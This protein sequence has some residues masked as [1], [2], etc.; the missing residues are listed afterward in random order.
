VTSTAVLSFWNW[1]FDENLIYTLTGVVSLMSTAGKLFLAL[2]V[3]T[4][5]MLQ[6][7]VAHLLV[8]SG[9]LETSPA[10]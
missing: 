3:R 10:L 9:V 6:S 4:R 1:D 7:R 8:Y 2:Y 5:R